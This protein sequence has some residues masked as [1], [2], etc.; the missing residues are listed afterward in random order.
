M[1]IQPRSIKVH[2]NDLR[3]KKADLFCLFYFKVLI[4]GMRSPLEDDGAN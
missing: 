3:Y 4:L 1:Q 2:L